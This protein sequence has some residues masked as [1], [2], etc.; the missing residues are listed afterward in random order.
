MRAKSVIL[1]SA[2]HK[3]NFN[4]A[5]G[6]LLKFMWHLCTYFIFELNK[7]TFAYIFNCV[8]IFFLQ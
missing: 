8:A 1:F 7:Q 3:F 4:L 2:L 5:A 6:F